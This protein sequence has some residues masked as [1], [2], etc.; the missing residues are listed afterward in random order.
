MRPR[1]HVRRLPR[2]RGI[3]LEPRRAPAV[4]T[5][6]NTLDAGAGSLRQAILNANAAAGADTV[7][8]DA[9]FATPKQITLTTGQL[10]VTDSLTVTGPGAGLLTVSGNTTGRVLLAS[11]TGTLDVILSGL[12]IAHGKTLTGNLGAGIY[13][14]GENLTLQNCVIT[15]NHAWNVGGVWVNTPGVLTLTDCQVTNNKSDIHGGGAGGSGGVVVTRSTI[16]GNTA[17]SRCGGLYAR[18][19]LLMQDSTVSGNSAGVNGG[20]MDLVDPGGGGTFV[21]RNSTISGNTAMF[22]GAGIVL[23]HYYTSTTFNGSLTV[24]NSTITNNSNV[25][26]YSVGPGIDLYSGGGSIAVESSII[27]GNK[28]AGVAEDISSH[29]TVT[30]KTSA[31]GSAAGFTNTDLGGNLPFGVDVKL[32]KLANNGGPTLTHGLLPLSP[33]IDKGSNPAGLA[34]DQRGA[35][36]VRSSGGGIDIGATE[37]R[38][39]PF[40]VTNAADAGP[41]S[42]RQAILDANNIIGPDTITFDP[43]FF[44]T[45]RTITLT[46]GQLVVTD[47]GTSVFGPGASLLTVSGNK[48]GRV[49]FFASPGAATL[50]LGS[51]TLSQGAADLGGGLYV[52]QEDVLYLDACKVTGN[53]AKFDGGGIFLEYNARLSPSNSTI[54]GNTAGECGGGIYF[55]N[56]GSLQLNSCTVS[57]NSAGTEGGGIYFFGTATSN[58]ILSGLTVSNSTISGNTAATNGGGVMLRNFGGFMNVFNTTVTANSAGAGGGLFRT[59]GNGLVS[60]ESSIVSGNSA[61]AGSGAEISTTQPI[62]LTSSLCGLDRNGSFQLFGST[63]FMEGK[64]PQLSPLADN[65]GPTLTHMIASS[66]PVINQGSNPNFLGFDQR[67][68]PR[69][70]GGAPDVGAVERVLPLVVTNADDAGFGSLRANVAEAGLIPGAD[71]ILFDPAFFNT[72]RTIMLTSG[73]I[74][75]NTPVAI[76]GPG[77]LL[78]T[79]SGNNASRVFQIGANAGD[80]ALV[81]L[82][83][84]KGFHPTLFGGGILSE[85]ANLTLQSCV[86]T[87]NSAPANGGG[88]I[89]A[90]DPGLLTLL[91]CQV[92]NNSTGFRVGGIVAAGGAVIR[93]STISGNTATGECGGLAVGG[94]LLLE[95]STVTENSAASGGGLW[96]L[97]PAPGPFIIRNSTISGNSAQSVGGGI[98]LGVNASAQFDGTLTLQNS[99]VTNNSVPFGTGGGI[100][101]ATGNGSI[102]LES[103]IASGNTA[104]AHPDI[105]SIK[106]VSL[107]TSA[108]GSGAGFTPTDLGGNLPFGADLKLAPLLNNGGQT[109][110]HALL[111]GSSA[112]GKGSNPAGLFNDQRGGGF[113][114]AV[115][116]VDIGAFE[117]QSAVAPP[118]V[119]S[120]VINAGAVQ[121][122]RVT[123]LT[124]NFDQAVTLPANPADA[125]QLKHLPDNAAV[126]LAASV[127]G[128]AVTLTFT[129]GSVNGTSLAD[130][131]YTLTVLASKVSAGGGSLDGNGDGTGGDDYVLVG[132]PANGLFRLFGDNDGDGDVDAQDFGAF[133]A[134]FGGTSNL[135]FDADGDGDVDAA[136]FGAFRARFGSS[137]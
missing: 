122:S 69:A 78:A 120:V 11:G 75:I 36:F 15:N 105:S 86:V 91:D 88:G 60:I 70:L 39:P 89:F 128:N 35:G 73:P 59:G 4:F 90:Y 65:G 82:T 32:G 115:G 131:R 30:L 108:V 132:T 63:G 21:I 10:I 134:A 27:S 94:S 23:G 24:H 104:A 101:L 53:S 25:S 56:R 96:L 52:G 31:I 77:A 49:L 113:A 109:L 2:L 72:P 99:T 20:G 12:T 112:I 93:R 26:H 43:A 48:S 135:N 46:S 111:P 50:T 110:T 18:T 1:S 38:L 19:S 83:V 55:F 71:T 97:N 126:T 100:A 137:V 58:G 33:A 51:V 129:G 103:T 37:A 16:S 127:S 118:R 57:G 119:S 79:V 17:A 116:A 76:A 85:G 107:K 117:N 6:T 41:G 74:Q 92:T 68:L 34:V 40:V 29:K 124:V 123:Q 54:S 114:R 14:A 44:A 95:D 64:N 80:V 8:F 98:L 87:G 66:S 9:S 42:L 121:R 84:T 22:N 81:G 102:A 13:A 125:F 45:A 106:S 28:V 7:A 5:V 62:T 136:D 130:G 133:R 3:E 67:G 61:S 47:A